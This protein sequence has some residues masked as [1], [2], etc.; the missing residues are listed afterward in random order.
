MIFITGHRGLVGSAIRRECKRQNIPYSYS[1]DVDYTDE[2][3]TY[4]LF[5]KNRPKKVIFASAKVGGILANNNNKID[6]LMDN[7]LQQHS[8]INAAMNSGVYQLLFLGSTCIYPKEAPQPLK[9]E[10][11]LTGSLEPT[12]EAYALAKITGIKMC[13]YINESMGL[14]F[15]SV[16]PTNLFGPRD[17][18]HPENSH[19]I[20]GLIQRFH[21]AV[22]SGESSVTVWGSGEPRREFMYVD[23]F[24]RAALHVMD[25]DYPPNLV[26]IGTGTDISIKELVK[27][28]SDITGYTGEIVFD[29]QMP[30]GTMV[31]RTDISLLKSLGWDHQYDLKG[32]IYSTYRSYVEELEN[33]TVRCK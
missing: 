15:H 14:K 33:G 20:P 17:N 21:E 8:I 30:D 25:L 26:N 32:D 2:N 27:I 18:Y 10:Y 7:L 24:A 12:N 19:V 6:F 29:K 13:Q 23:H 1:N 4:N 22:C 11:L 28:I 3:A 16:M 31:K 9:E 5:K